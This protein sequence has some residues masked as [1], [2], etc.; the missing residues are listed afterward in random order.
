MGSL[1]A[2]RNIL[3]EGISIIKNAKLE[4]AN[5]VSEMYGALQRQYTQVR[6]IKLQGKA[7]DY[8][9]KVLHDSKFFCILTKLITQAINQSRTLKQQ[10]TNM[11]RVHKWYTSNLHKL[12]FAEQPALRASAIPSPS[13][14]LS[15]SHSRQEKSPR[16]LSQGTAIS[17]PSTPPF[18][19]PPSS[20]STAPEN[21]FPETSAGEAV[22]G[23][24]ES[25]SDLNR[26]ISKAS[27]R[28]I[29][30]PSSLRRSREGKRPA[31][32]KSVTWQEPREGAK[33]E[34]TAS[35]SGEF[36]ERETEN[37]SDDGNSPSSPVCR[38]RRF[39][40][41]HSVADRRTP[42]YHLVDDNSY[43]DTVSKSNELGGRNSPATR[44]FTP[45]VYE[46][47]EHIQKEVNKVQGHPSDIYP[48]LFTPH[49]VNALI[50]ENEEPKTLHLKDVV[51]MVDL[52]SAEISYQKEAGLSSIL[53]RP[54]DTPPSLNPPPKMLAIEAPSNPIEVDVVM[55]S[56][57]PRPSSGSPTPS[58]SLNP[59]VDWRGR[60]TPTCNDSQQDM[61]K[62]H[63]YARHSA[64]ASHKGRP[65]GTASGGYRPNTASASLSQRS[66]T[67]DDKE[68][69]T[70]ERNTKSA[71]KARVPQSASNTLVEIDKGTTKALLNITNMKTT[72]PPRHKSAPSMHIV[73][74]SS[75]LASAYVDFMDSDYFV[76]P[77]S[78]YEYESYPYENE[79]IPKSFSFMEAEEGADLSSPKHLEYFSIVQS[80]GPDID[81]LR[82][83]IKQEARI[84]RLNTPASSVKTKEST[85]GTAANKEDGESE[86]KDPPAADKG[87][88]EEASSPTNI[89]NR[90]LAAKSLV[91]SPMFQY[92]TY[93]TA[94]GGVLRTRSPQGRIM[95]STKESNPNV[96]DTAVT[97]I[98]F[99]APFD[100]DD[101]STE[102]SKSAGK[103]RSSLDKGQVMVRPIRSAPS[104]PTMYNEY[105]SRSTSLSRNHPFS[106]EHDRS[107]H[108]HLNPQE[109]LRKVQAMRSE[110]VIV[111][112]KGREGTDDISTYLEVRPMSSRKEVLYP[113]LS[114]SVHNAIRLDKP[115]I[116][117]PDQRLCSTPAFM[118]E[119]HGGMEVSPTQEQPSTGRVKSA[120]SISPSRP[121]SSRPIPQYMKAEKWEKVQA[122]TERQREA[123]AAVSIQRI[124]R[125]Y[126]SRKVY[127]SLRREVR[128][129]MENKRMSAVKIQRSWREHKRKLTKIYEKPSVS[130]ETLEWAREVK[131]TQQQASLDRQH[132]RDSEI[133]QIKRQGSSSKAR[134]SVIGP[135]VEVYSAYHP[136][137]TGVSKQECERAAIKI[138]KLV[139]GVQCRTYINTVKEKAKGH[140][141]SWPE[142]VNYYKQFLRKILKRRGIDKP[143]IELNLE[144]MLKFMA[145]KK[146]YE[147]VFERRAFGG[148]LEE[149]ELVQF[150][151]ECDLMPA[152]HEIEHAMDLVFRGS[153]RGNRTTLKKREVLDVVFEIYKPEG[154]GIINDRKSTWLH[155]IV[156]GEDAM[157][158]IGT[159]A[160]E[161]TPLRPCLQLV[162]NSM[163]E[164]KE[165]EEEEERLRLLAAT[166]KK[167]SVTSSPRSDSNTDDNKV[168]KD[169]DGITTTRSEPTK[170]FSDEPMTSSISK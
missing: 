138:Q 22:M 6:T 30:P 60:V 28:D 155:P 94:K 71:G 78:I 81:R 2:E 44:S 167:S 165:R 147:G 157:K 135:H 129:E 114:M 55:D 169:A 31:R 14:R 27:S 132:K 39:D 137:K 24:S 23:Q 17:P 105:G 54:K 8:V 47:I 10:M 87:D 151:R 53:N 69:G 118:T 82:S 51:S 16:Y 18:R 127:L 141:A 75:D 20:P 162:A 159:D 33:Y 168:S 116:E 97:A 125:G 152:N 156:D 5:P 131:L 19:G 36:F 12:H 46:Y 117:I 85:I 58:Q 62:S 45:V 128:A 80:V 26:P 65:V 111:E 145:Q 41:V 11:D 67:A 70:N 99:E 130:E 124:F 115:S 146:R 108:R 112:D 59:V 76:P 79:P 98:R 1:V 77:S 13:L 40:V 101:F 158:L 106:G 3:E 63:S 153:P 38:R 89:K 148:E 110:E 21:I 34:E 160:I 126:V 84:E 57:Q 9:R 113:D 56:M 64:R 166:N 149:E 43:I 139:R 119:S 144:Q 90:L 91:P 49:I 161:P 121:D 150:L 100:G 32:P 95:S 136:A 7:Q 74:C 52:A 107:A 123:A 96:L 86:S 109:Y 143:S 170:I 48:E 134:I 72:S 15:S 68:T 142:W 122:D 83:S 88:A 50:D 164:R 4:F 103:L 42:D 35:V 66:K 25:E 154:T 163:R 120:K 133:S 29:R 102:K 93:P 37:T 104:I 61:F 140:A 92:S 73:C